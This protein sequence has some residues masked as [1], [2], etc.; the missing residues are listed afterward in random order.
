[1]ELTILRGPAE[2]GAVGDVAVEVVLVA[3]EARCREVQ[4]RGEPAARADGGEGEGR[5]EEWGYCGLVGLVSVCGLELG[6]WRR[7]AYGCLYYSTPRH[8][9]PVS[10]D[11][12]QTQ[13]PPPGTQTQGQFGQT[14]STVSIYS[15]TCN[16][17]FWKTWFLITLDTATTLARESQARGLSG[18]CSSD[19][20]VIS[21]RVDYGRGESLSL[22]N[23]IPR[24]VRL[25]R[26]VLGPG[27]G[28]KGVPDVR[29]GGMCC[30]A[31][32]LSLGVVSC[33]CGPVIDRSGSDMAN[34]STCE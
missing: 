14:S 2:P 32:G 11:S 3:G 5:V 27:N 29:W 23:E 7:K 34:H 21:R 12:R 20:S 22:R 15:A 31:H 4:L 18:S 25:F 10:K 16:S 19:R 24:R 9:W 13:S 6:V 26:V 17:T 28:V 1:M 33:G 30:D 8:P